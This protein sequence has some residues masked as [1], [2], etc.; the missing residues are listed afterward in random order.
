[1]INRPITHQ[2]Y[3]KNLDRD[4]DILYCELSTDEL[5]QLIID[6]AATRKMASAG[7]DLH[8]MRKEYNRRTRRQEGK[9]IISYK[10][11]EKPDEPEDFAKMLED[12]DKAPNN[13]LRR[14]AVVG[15]MTAKQEKF[16]MECVATG[17]LLH[18]YIAAGY[19]QGK[20]NKNTMQRAKNLFYNNKK[21]KRRI[22]NLKEEALRRMSWNADKV[23]DKVA[24]VYEKLCQKMISLML[25]VVWKP[26]RG[27][28]VCLLTSL[29][30]GLN[31]LTSLM[32]IVK[33]KL[34]KILRTLRKLLG[35]KWLTAGKNKNPTPKI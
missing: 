27:I 23:L 22:E 18:A 21:I 2:D 5:K 33:I 29:N 26:L 14:S 12:T 28:W 9:K 25:T 10:Q 24:S 20:D 4:A 31:C 32:R 11:Y 8:Q 13:F 34:K 7:K 6:T 17:D 15:G 35:L 16:A 30:K 3:T 19:S 1:M